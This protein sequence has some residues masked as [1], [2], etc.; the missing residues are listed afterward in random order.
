[1][2]DATELSRPV[3][4][5]GQR[6]RAYAC[7]KI[8]LAPDGWIVTIKEPTRTLE[9]NARFWAMLTDLSKQK[10]GGIVATP[11]D[12]R[13]LVMHACG[14]ECQFLQGLD[15]R[16]FPVGFRSSQLTVRQMR[17]LMEW[18]A[19]YGDEQGVIWSEP[20]SAAA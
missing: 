11:D 5:V 7:H 4:L 2:I 18:M 15:G 6:Q 17:D 20:A 10:A 3:R 16:P 1:M 19:A 8:G 13:A 9:Q 12:W 14:F